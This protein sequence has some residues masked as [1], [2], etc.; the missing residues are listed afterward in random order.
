MHSRCQL[1][2][3]LICLLLTVSSGLAETPPVS[4][5]LRL[6]PAQTDLVLEIPN[7][8]QVHDLVLGLD[9][10]KELQKFAT[11]REFLETTT[12][13]RFQQLLRYYEK[14]LGAS[15]PDLVEKLT[16]GGIAI[17]LTFGNEP[18]QL[19]AVIQGKDEKL[20]QEFTTRALKILE[21]EL[22]RQETKDRPEPFSYHGVAGVHVGKTVHVAVVGARILVANQ[23]QVLEQSIDLALNKPGKSLADNPTLAE[24]RRLLPS[25][26]LAWAWLNMETVRK[27]PA[28]AAFYKTPREPF[29][30][31]T[32][33]ALLDVLGQVPFVAA[34]VFRTPEGIT[35]TVR[36][37][38]GLECM[39]P[40]KALH[41]PL[42]AGQTV[43]RP[44]LKPHGVIY[45][46][47]SYFDY[48]RVWEDR[49]KLFPADAVTAMEKF[50][51]TSAKLPFLNLQFSKVL[52]SLAPY[53]RTVLAFQPQVGYTKKKPRTALPAFAMVFELRE[54]AFAKTLDSSLRAA[55][56]FGNQLGLKLA[57][58]TYHETTLVAYRFDE[59]KELRQDVNDIRFNFSPCFATVGNQY[60]VC[61]TIELAHELVDQLKAEAK[62]GV[63]PVTTK[64]SVS[65]F[66]PGIADILGQYEDQ[67]VTQTILDQAVSVA[68]AKEQIKTFLQLLR[69]QGTMSLES[70]YLPRAVH[71]DLAIRA[72]P[73]DR[74][75]P[76]K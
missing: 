52:T 48:Q 44:L 21:Q 38:K 26:L 36:L 66:A 76:G 64:N 34:G 62:A 68:D 45:S 42:D 47:T 53:S 3:S 15:Y 25:Q 35:T 73:A 54:V 49:G 33:G 23:P 39:G 32:M 65:F 14:E 55:A 11:T 22:Q 10:V 27:A 75:G 37:P 69:K 46:D 8:R 19:L 16:G 30:T 74:T 41:L 18:P 43:S 5:P 71:F 7:V 58:E 40:D 17:G 28:A 12:Y 70:T 67:L 31:V 4:S 72:R 56:L 1:L 61:S 57:E 6:L 29:F 50:N 13:R 2:G 51:K 9:L 59:D 24:A 63:P 60:L 20:T